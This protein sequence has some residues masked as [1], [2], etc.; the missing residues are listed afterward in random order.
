MSAAAPFPFAIWSGDILEKSRMRTTDFSTEIRREENRRIAIPWYKA[1]WQLPKGERW[2]PTY[3]GAHAQMRHPSYYDDYIN[4]MKDTPDFW[5]HGLPW[6]FAN[7]EKGPDPYNPREIRPGAPTVI[8]F[9]LR[10]FLRR[11]GYDRDYYG[12]VVNDNIAMHRADIEDA[13][14][15]TG[16]NLVSGKKVPSVRS[17][18]RMKLRF[19]RMQGDHNAVLRR[20]VYFFHPDA[21]R[22]MIRHLEEGA[23]R[24]G[25]KGDRAPVERGGQLLGTVNIDPESG[26]PWVEI[27]HYV[28]Y[29]PVGWTSVGP[30]PGPFEYTSRTKVNP[31]TKAIEALQKKYPHLTVMGKVH[32]HPPG[33]IPTPSNADVRNDADTATHPYHL[34]IIHSAN[35]IRV[36]AQYRSSEEEPNDPQHEYLHGDELAAHLRRRATARIESDNPSGMRFPGDPVAGSYPSPDRIESGPH[37][38]RSPYAE[39][40]TTFWNGDRKPKRSMLQGVRSATH[41]ATGIGRFNLP[42]TINFMGKKGGP[43]ILPNYLGIREQGDLLRVPAKPS[44]ISN[45]AGAV[46]VH[47]PRSGALSPAPEYPVFGSRPRGLETNKEKIWGSDTRVNQEPAIILDN[48]RLR[49]GKELE[50]ISSTQKSLQNP[51][52]FAIWPHRT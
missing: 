19:Q 42:Y 4:P 12:N 21:H 44:D 26:T 45:S 6:Q 22:D 14:L 15:V 17:D 48:P 1:K 36:P 11:H 43:A 37:Q 27:T 8:P 20:P 13:R 9:S 47:R 38:S 51:F 24:F 30:F 10:T 25:E 34:D 29:A 39:A 5:H 52:P 40:S 16:E 41:I 28:P 33:S 3:H 49:I 50:D 46:T 2:D 7:I 32:S 18:T 31:D 35:S 23:Q